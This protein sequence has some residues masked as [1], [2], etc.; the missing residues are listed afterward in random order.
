MADEPTPADDRLLRAGALA[1]E[2]WRKSAK[3]DPDLR[4]KM[5]D[6]IKTN[7]PDAEIPGYEART[8]FDREAA[9]LRKLREQLTADAERDK[10]TRL[11]DTEREKIIRLGLA[12][13]EDIPE[14]E[15]LMR[16]RLIGDHTT[17]AEFY[18]RSREIAAPRSSAV[19]EVP[20]INGAGGAEFKWLA[21]V[22]EGS[23]EDLDKAT[24]K[25]AY[26]VLDEVRAGH[27]GS[28]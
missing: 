24:L 4:R 15:K 10:T 16:D 18:R 8:A 26:R 7:H 1:T 2:M 22:A 14:I 21:D 25:E 12:T 9:E 5:E 20:G 23:R 19:I 27:A 11:L 6:W 3:D 28:L 17:A 13:R